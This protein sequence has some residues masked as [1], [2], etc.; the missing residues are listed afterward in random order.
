MCVGTLSSLVRTRALV[1]LG[2]PGGG[3]GTISK[4]ILKWSGK[5]AHFQGD[6]ARSR[7]SHLSIGDVLRSNVERGTPLGQQVGELMKTG[8]LV[9]DSLILNCLSDE[10]M[11]LKAEKFQDVGESSA[12]AK[13]EQEK[14]MHYLLLDGFP[15][16]VPQA[17]FLVSPEVGIVDAQD[18]S[19]QL[20]V[21][22][23]VPVEEIVERI[24]S[25]WIHRPTGRTYNLQY[26]P[27][28]AWSAERDPKDGLVDDETGEPLERRPDDE[29]EVVDARLRTYVENQQPLLEFFTSQDRLIRF[30]GSTFPDL[31]GQGKRSDAIVQ[32]ML[33]N[34]RLNNFWGVL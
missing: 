31:V 4:H 5:Q 33:V 19:S 29:P 22:L 27:P 11:R 12:K 25:R 16:T 18:S 24:S 20:A 6:N 34:E 30:S 23:D 1:L 8:A 9:N 28:R 13:E 15:R 7:L 3:K 21:Q 32:E 14:H 26:N 2:A 17:E 10:V